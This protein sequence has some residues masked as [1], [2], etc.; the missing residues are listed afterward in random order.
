MRSFVEGVGG[1]SQEEFVNIAFYPG[2]FESRTDS[3]SFSPSPSLSFSRSRFRSF[4][5]DKRSIPS[6]GF[7]DGSFVQQFLDLS[8]SK[9]DEIMNGRSEYEKLS[10]GKNE[11]VKVLEE[12]GR[13][14]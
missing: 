9:Q 12:V 10:V 4:K 11:V 13:L 8:P 2:E 7:V 14:H 3:V 5:A 1:L 6:T